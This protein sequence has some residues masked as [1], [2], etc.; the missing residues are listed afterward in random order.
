MVN[1]ASRL[2][3]ANKLFGTTII[4]SEATVALTGK[5]FSWRELDA[6]RVKGRSQAVKIYEPLGETDKVPLDAVVA[7]ANLCRG[8]RVLSRPRF[9]RGRG[10]T[11]PLRNPRPACGADPRASTATGQKPPGPDWEPVNTQDE[12]QDDTAHHRHP[13]RRR[14]AAA[15]PSGDGPE[16]RVAGPSILGTLIGED[17]SHDGGERYPHIP[18]NP[19]RPS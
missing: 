18:A 14:T 2:E 5:T 8:P 17:S 19:H 10:K 13:R 15:P 6:L 4:A 16:L 7:G 9:R 3:G 1:L 12:K 11:L